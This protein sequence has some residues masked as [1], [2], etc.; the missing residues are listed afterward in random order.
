M[1]VWIMLLP[2]TKLL[3]IQDMH[4]FQSL[5][6]YATPSLL[7]L[8]APSTEF[9]LFVNIRILEPIETESSSMLNL[10]LF[11]FVEEVSSGGR[12]VRLHVERLW[13]QITPP[14]PFPV[15]A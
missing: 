9:L 1:P 15:Q 10:C 13:V 6:S 3:L 5:K 8:L 14:P 4:V 12:A 2:T 7:P 11:S